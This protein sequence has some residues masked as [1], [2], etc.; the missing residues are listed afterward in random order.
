[1]DTSPNTPNSS[2]SQTCQPSP[3]FNPFRMNMPPPLYA[4]NPMFMQP[5][6][7]YGYQMDYNQPSPQASPYLPTQ[8]AYN[9]FRY[10]TQFSPPPTFEFD[11][12]DIRPDTL[13]GLDSIPETMPATQAPSGSR[14]KK[15]ARATTREPNTKRTPEEEVAF[16]KGL[17]DVSEDDQVGNAQKI[18]L[19]GTAFWSTSTMKREYR[20]ERPPTLF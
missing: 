19:F 16:A 3:G 1:M 13:E 11:N 20:P 6:F 5:Q 17:V 7:G 4:P 8:V 12:N 14:G 18:I 10:Q 2:R 9:E 15:P